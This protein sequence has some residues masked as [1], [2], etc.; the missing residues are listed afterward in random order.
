MEQPCPFHCFA[1]ALALAKQ[2]LA[3]RERQGQEEGELMFARLLVS[4]FSF[5]L[6]PVS[7]KEVGE[8]ENGTVSLNSKRNLRPHLLPVAP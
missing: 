5:L 7:E 1:L 6:R 2:L 8:G 3:G 4:S